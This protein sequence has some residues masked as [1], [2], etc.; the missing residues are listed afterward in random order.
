[1]GRLPTSYQRTT[2]VAAIAAVTGR[3]GRILEGGPINSTGTI[4]GK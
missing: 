4:N 3:G 2:A 1:M